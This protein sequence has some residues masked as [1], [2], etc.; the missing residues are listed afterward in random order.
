MPLTSF[1][2]STALLSGLFVGLLV[3]VL[4]PVQG[5]AYG[6]PPPPT[7]DL[8]DQAPRPFNGSF[9]EAS[10]RGG[11]VLSSSDDVDRGWGS[12][13]RLRTS[14]PMYLADHSLVYDVARLGDSDN[15]VQ[16][17]GLQ[18]T[19]AVHPFYLALLSEGLMSHFLASLHAEVG[20]GLRYGRASDG[21]IDASLGIATSLSGGFD[22]PLSSP[23]R[24]RSLWLNAQYRRTW[25]SLTLGPDDAQRLHDHRFFLGLAFRAN[26][27]LW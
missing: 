18:S 11:P 27:V 14:F 20:F 3:L 4:P 16:V 1:K 26:G 6:E 10:L 15:R 19:F 5:T 17:H 8:V 22:L 24:G 12:E 21:D 7:P 2:Q 9:K 23:N 13:A 25:T